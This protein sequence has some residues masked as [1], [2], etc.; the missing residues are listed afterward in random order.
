MGPEV[1]GDVEVVIAEESLESQWNV[2]TLD[3]SVVSSMIR[4][5]IES[6]HS[7]V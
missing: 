6:L 2:T 4:R 7:S 3:L 1:Y 5:R